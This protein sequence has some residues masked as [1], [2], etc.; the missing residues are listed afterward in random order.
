MF[1]AF[2]SGWYS[3][4]LF[5][6]FLARFLLGE[7]TRFH[8]K[9]VVTSFLAI[10]V[11]ISVFLYQRQ[12]NLVYPGKGTAKFD[13]Q[14]IKYDLLTILKFTLTGEQ[15]RSQLSI[16]QFLGISIFLIAVIIAGK[17]RFDFRTSLIERN[18]FWFFLSFVAEYVLVYF[19]D[20]APGPGLWGRYLLVPSGTLILFI[21]LIAGEKLVKFFSIGMALIPMTALAIV[22]PQY[23]LTS[24]HYLLNCVEP[25]LSWR[26]NVKKVSTGEA[27]AYYFWPF[28]AGNP[29][30]AISSINPQVRFAPFQAEKMGLPVVVLPPIETVK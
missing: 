16:L 17:F 2:F 27:S 22:V 24:S 25:C 9:V 18:G 6:L 4:I 29:D 11:Q 14:E 30:W 8:K 21:A 19:G 13:L 28:N 26:E 23:A 7:R 5:P 1:L 12:N 10:C 15:D 3:A 20:A